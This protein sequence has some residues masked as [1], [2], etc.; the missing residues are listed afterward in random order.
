[1]GRT[2]LEY[3]QKHKIELFALTTHSIHLTQPLDVGCFQPYKHYHSEAIDAAMRTRIPKFSKLDFL[4]SLTTMR[5]KTF[6]KSTV[7]SAFKKTDLIPYNP[8][9]VLQKIRT[10][11]HLLPPSR[12]VTPPPPAN[13]FS[14]ICNETPRRCE[15]VFSQA[16]T[17][18]NTIQKGKR[19]VHQKFRPHL[20]K[21]IRGFLTSAFT[22]SLFGREESKK[23]ASQRTRKGGNQVASS[24]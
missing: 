4:A 15:K 16:R 21:F 3:V 9:M 17:L 2:L 10:T 13:P 6:Q 24:G 22:H 18:L 5:A 7:L 23:E 8:E 11:N 19:L 20:W 14:G 1:M 12:P